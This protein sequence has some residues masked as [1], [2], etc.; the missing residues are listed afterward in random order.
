M[1]CDCSGATRSLCRGSRR[2]AGVLRSKSSQWLGALR[3]VRTR[4]C[5]ARASGAPLSG[6]RA[7]A[8]LRARGMGLGAIPGRESKRMLAKL[9]SEIDATS[10]ERLLVEGKELDQEA[11]CALT[12]ESAPG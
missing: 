8:R 11:V 12:L 5:W 10:L 7:V 2:T 4:L 3:R 1:P 9:Q 6:R